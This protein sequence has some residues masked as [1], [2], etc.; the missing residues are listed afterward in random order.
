MA[1]AKAGSFRVVPG[2]SESEK[3]KAKWGVFSPRD[4]EE[5]FRLAGEEKFLIEELIPEQSLILV[6]GESGLGKSP[7][8][9]QK[10]LCVAKGIPFLGC[11]VRQAKVLYVD[12]ENGKRDVHER[13]GDLCGFLGLAERPTLEELVVFNLAMTPEWVKHGL[14]GLIHEFKPGLVIL[15]PLSALYPDCEKTNSDASRVWLGLRS[16][17]R[18]FQCSIEVVHHLRKESEKVPKAWLEDDVRGFFQRVRGASVLVNGADVRIGVD[19]PNGSGALI[20]EVELVMGGFGRMRGLIPLWRL[21]RVLDSDGEAIGYRKVS[22]V[23]LL[24]NTE[25]QKAFAALGPHFTFGDAVKEYGKGKQPTT[26]WL[27]KC[28]SVGIVRKVARGVYAKTV[29]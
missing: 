1:A 21:A 22:A 5:E 12:C 8:E 18:E 29:D 6:A 13:L 9:Y 23:E 25:Q 24:G 14:W 19:R 10:A 2:P 7:L 28:I 15:D 16:Y 11:A 26:N 4:L 3:L 17:I 27:A 20:P